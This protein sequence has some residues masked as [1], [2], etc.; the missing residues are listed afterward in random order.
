MEKNERMKKNFLI[1]IVM[2]VMFL[3]TGTVYAVE[4]EEENTCK[5]TQLS[6]LR[7]LAANV[8]VTYIP[9]AVVEDFGVPDGEAGATAFTQQ[10]LY[11]KI[12]NLTDK[13]KIYVSNGGRGLTDTLREKEF[14]VAQAG[15]DGAVTLRQAAI[16]ENVQYIFEIK[17]DYYG[18]GDKTLRKFNLTLPKF[19]FYSQLDI[20]QDVPE[21]YLCQQYTTFDVDGATFYDKVNEYKAKLLAQKE[22]NEAAE[23]EEIDN[24]TLVS[25]AMSVVSKNKYI[26]VGVIVVIGVVITV[27]I[28]KRKGRVL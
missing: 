20:C 23:N 9:M 17:S 27:V 21:Y 25:K 13:L 2:L 15:S 3:C 19:N 5:A 24:T 14:T 7:S 26:V 16:T 11:V 6:E 8:K 28:L 18:C 22:E 1:L 4:E 12:Y 10:Y